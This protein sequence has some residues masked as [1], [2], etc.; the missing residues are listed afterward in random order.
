MNIHEKLLG[1]H[2]VVVHAGA[3]YSSLESPHSVFLEHLI[4]FLEY[5]FITHVHGFCSSG[6]KKFQD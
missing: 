6:Y 2:W 4:N 1:S 3:E 5:L